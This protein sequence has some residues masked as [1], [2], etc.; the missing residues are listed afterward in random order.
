MLQKVALLSNSQVEA[1]IFFVK[2]LEKQNTEFTREN[3]VIVNDSFIAQLL[4]VFSELKLNHLYFSKSDKEKLL[5]W[6]DKFLD[7]DDYDFINKNKELVI[8]ELE[9]V[10]K[11]FGDEQPKIA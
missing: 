9:K 11:F 4:N 3:L 8:K 10:K 7:Q 6:L 2:K 1:F 5:L